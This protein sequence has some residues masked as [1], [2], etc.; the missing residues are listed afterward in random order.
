MIF[1]NHII[2]YLGVC[3]DLHIADVLGLWRSGDDGG[4]RLRSRIDGGQGLGAVVL[5][6]HVLWTSVG[7]QLRQVGRCEVR[8]R[9]SGSVDRRRD[10]QGL[11]RE[12]WT[13]GSSS[14]RVGEVGRGTGP[15]PTQGVGG[16]A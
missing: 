5:L 2:P 8:S 13:D 4:Q 11:S 3:W 12:I 6:Q 16:R 10:V 15:G 14:V 1:Y 9:T 7:G